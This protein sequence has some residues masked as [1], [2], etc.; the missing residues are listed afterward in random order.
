MKTKYLTPHLKIVEYV[1]PR[2]CLM[3]SSIKISNDSYVEDEEDIGFVKEDNADYDEN[4][5]GD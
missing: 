4:F 5:W 1:A 2:G 3:I